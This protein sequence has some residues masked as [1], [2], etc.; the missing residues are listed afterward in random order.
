MSLEMKPPVHVKGKSTE[1]KSS[2]GQTWHGGCGCE[3][4]HH[5]QDPEQAYSLQGLYVEM[6]VT[7]NKWPN[8]EKYIF[9]LT[10]TGP[11]SMGIFLF[12]RVIVFQTDHVL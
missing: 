3:Q 1:E 10:P 4:N 8:P 6:T 2:G 5:C 9:L 12:Q 7:G 11:Q